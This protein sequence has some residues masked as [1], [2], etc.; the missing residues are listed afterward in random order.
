MRL[1]IGTKQLFLDDHLVHEMHGLRR[2]MHQPVK[3]G[4]VLKADTPSDGSLV[5]SVSSP[6]WIPDEG[7]YKLVYECRGDNGGWA[8]AV[9]EDGVHWAKPNLGAMEFEGSKDNNL[10]DAPG[11]QRL[12]QVIYDPDDADSKRRY[13]G[14]LGSSGRRPVVSAD[15]VHWEVL[16]VPSLPSGDAGT[17]CFDRENRLFIGPL[18]FH[19]CHGRAYNVSTSNDFVH[20]SEPRFLFGTDDEDQELALE[21]IRRRLADPGLAKPLMV[22]PDPGVGWTAPEGKTHNATWR[23]ECYNIGVFRYEEVYVALLMIYYPTGQWIPDRRNTDGFDVIQLAMTRDLENWTR[24]GERQAFMETSRIDEDGLVGNYD[25][26]QMCVSNGPIERGDELWFYYT[27]MKRRVPVHEQ[28]TDG[29]LR[30]PGTLT[31]LE[32]ADW[33][34]DTHSAICL[35]VLRRDGF[36]SLDAAADEGQL[37]TKPLELGGAGLFLNLDAAGGQARVEVLDESG[38]PIPGFAGDQ[39]AM[40]TGNEVSLPARWP[41]ETGLIALAGRT[42][43]LRINL[44]QAS[45]YALWVE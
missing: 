8:L 37:L 3:R 42:V 32:R 34:E 19:G 25:R 23:A 14:F 33:L 30:D 15:C 12:W 22:D 26:L 31:A 17:L 16:D 28:Y 27:G 20:W 4:A 1:E 44:K 7:V 18:K 24:L 36:V 29:S 38:D 45:L 5:A 43:R 21:V 13:K 11:G 9:S 35:A 6:M 40:V 39:A 41:S 10:I 2:T